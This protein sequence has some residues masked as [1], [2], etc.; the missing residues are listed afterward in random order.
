MLL[1]RK[2]EGN[3]FAV[4]LVA[5][6]IGAWVGGVGPSLLG[7]TLLLVA[8]SAWFTQTEQAPSHLSTVRGITNLIAFYSV[9]IVVAVLSEARSA[10]SRRVREQNAKIAAQ[11]GELQATLSGIG[12][13][14]AVADQSGRI[15]FMNPMAEFIT[16]W[17]IHDAQGEPLQAVLSIVEE[18]DQPLSLDPLKKVIREG[19]SIREGRILKLISRDGRF[20]PVTYNATP[21]RGNSD[22]V[23]GCVMVLRDESDRRRAE[24][25]L[26]EMNRRKDDFLAM[27]AHEL[28]N[29]IA[30]RFPRGCSC[31]NDRATWCSCRASRSLLPQRNR[32]PARG[33][34]RRKF[35]VRRHACAETRRAAAAERA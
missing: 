11:K 20:V 26:V 22:E 5:I 1:D 32:A 30:G 34:C 13:G 31:S 15:R 4:F 21:I 29:P 10:A 18:N 23:I 17:T 19:K 7:Q 33:Q 3:G 24:E 8:Q 35:S 27:L 14:I 9:G 25:Q 12:D 6:L 28:R 2:L 16:G